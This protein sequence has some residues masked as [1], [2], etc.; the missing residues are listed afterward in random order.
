MTQVEKMTDIIAKFIGHTA[1]KLPDDVIAPERR[2]E[3]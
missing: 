1:K 2:A 3:G